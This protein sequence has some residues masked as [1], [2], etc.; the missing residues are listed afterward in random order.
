[1][2]VVELSEINIAKCRKILRRVKNLRVKNILEE[3]LAVNTA[4]SVA[5][6]ELDPD[7]PDN[8][9]KIISKKSFM[10]RKKGLLRK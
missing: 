1:M 7:F 10:S 4:L 5:Q 6:L 8:F 9:A 3:E 2:S